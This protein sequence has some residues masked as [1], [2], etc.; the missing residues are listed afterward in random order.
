MDQEQAAVRNSAGSPTIT[1][2]SA[3][4]SKDCPPLTES[5]T[6]E[7]THFPKRVACR[8]AGCTAPHPATCGMW[9]G[10]VQGCMVGME[11]EEKGQADAA[12]IFSLPAP[13]H[14]D[15]AAAH[16]RQH[17]PDI[18]FRAVAAP[19]HLGRLDAESG[20]WAGMGHRSAAHGQPPA[21]RMPRPQHRLHWRH[22]G[23]S[24]PK[25]DSALQLLALKALQDSALHSP[26]HAPHSRRSQ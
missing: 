1:L 3:V 12:A 25:T 11:R 7:L 14:C 18:A 5:S 9:G 26:L 23:R 19:Q 8:T 21:C 13:R 24:Q 4:C 17:P 10:G 16:H 6:D 2:D 15:Q 22:V 20:T